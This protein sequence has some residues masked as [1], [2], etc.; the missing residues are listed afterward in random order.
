M[1]SKLSN[2]HA[3]AEYTHGCYD[4]LVFKKIKALLGGEVKIMATGSAPIDKEVLAFLKV[5]F[6]VPIIEGYGLS[7]T[8]AAATSTAYEDPVLSHVGGPMR[9]NKLRLRDVPE[10]NYFSTDKPYPRGEVQ[11][12]GSNVF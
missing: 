6:A 12:M 3:N 10:M 4:F 5:A 2:Y 7:E 1:S 8:A 11:M 9:C